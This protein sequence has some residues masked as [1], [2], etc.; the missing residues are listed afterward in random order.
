MKVN[1]LEK[2]H[3]LRTFVGEIDTIVKMDRGVVQ[4]LEAGSKELL[5]NLVSEGADTGFVLI[6]AI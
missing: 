2:C 3:V 1:I 4:L 6:A 5:C